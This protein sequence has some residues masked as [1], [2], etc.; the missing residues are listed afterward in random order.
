MKIFLSLFTLFILSG[1]T[2]HT[3]NITEYSLTTVHPSSADI[4]TVSS[5]KT[6]QLATTK[7]LPSLNSKSIFYLKTNQEIGS[8]LYSRWIDTPSSM[9]ENAF[10][11]VLQKSAL[12]S[13][14]IPASS[15]A[16]GD[17]LLESNLHAFYH[18]IHD[19]QTSDGVIDITYRLI[20]TKS[21]A[22]VATKRFTLIHPSQT[23][24]A[25]GGVD[26]L[27]NALNSLNSQV[28]QWLQNGIAEKKI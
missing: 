15:H 8:Y 17:Y 27:N 14:V 26:A 13:A 22:T 19:N 2:T 21:K 4:P 3:P 24:N 12:F 28:V 11:A 9:I 1:C 5:P 7:T 20:N 23:N 25:K 18:R 6:L 16:N 10:T